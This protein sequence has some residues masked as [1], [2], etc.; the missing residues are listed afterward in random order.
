MPDTFKD[1]LQKLR[2]TNFIKSNR[3]FDKLITDIIEYADNDKETAYMVGRLYKINN[4]SNRLPKNID[5]AII[6]YIKNK[7]LLDFFYSKAHPKFEQ[8]KYLITALLFIAFAL[9][10]S[11]IIQLHN[12]TVKVGISSRYLVPV[13]S[14][15]GTKI[16][17][18]ILLLIGCLLRYRYK[19]RKQKFLASL[20]SK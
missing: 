19:K 8:S 1:I 16:I 14:E 11:G 17:F 9:V 20:I 5:D 18:G 7:N 6:H 3:D 4:F 13:V 12:S 2:A 10:L 15:G